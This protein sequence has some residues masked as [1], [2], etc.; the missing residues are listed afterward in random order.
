MGC[1]GRASVEKY[2]DIST[3]AERLIQCIE[4]VL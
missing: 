4:E 1:R 2:H 3:L